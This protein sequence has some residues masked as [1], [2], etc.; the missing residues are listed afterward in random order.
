MYE[1]VRPVTASQK[2]EF[3]HDREPFDRIVFGLNGTHTKEGEEVGVV[4][5]ITALENL[6]V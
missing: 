4:R 1:V 2:C 3:R 5:E 6:L